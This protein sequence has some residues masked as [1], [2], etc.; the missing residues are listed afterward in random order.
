MARR[1][2][3]QKWSKI[4]EPLNPG[5]LHWLHIPH[6]FAASRDPLGVTCFV[7]LT[8]SDADPSALAYELGLCVIEFYELILHWVQMLRGV[9]VLKMISVTEV[10]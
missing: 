7:R 2:T 5:G 3:L 6:I 8:H 9:C 1:Y 10:F 4:C